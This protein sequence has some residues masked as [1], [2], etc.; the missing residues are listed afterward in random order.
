[1]IEHGAEETLGIEGFPPERSMYET[2]L[3]GSRLHR[4]KSREW[5]FFP[6]DAKS[7]PAL[8][9][10]WRAI[11][12]F[13]ANSEARRLS[14]DQLF[15][16]LRN[17]PFGLKDGI[18]PILAAVML[19][20]FDSEVALYEDG[21]FV[22]RLSDSVFERMFKTPERFELQR[23]RIAGPRF[24]VFRKYAQVLSRT[25]GNEAPD[26]ITLVRP[27]VR[28]V[29]ELPEFVVKTRQLSPTAQALLRAIRE[30][31]QPDKLLFADIP[32]A[33]GFA[34]FEAEG[35]LAEAELDRFFGILRASLAELQRAYPQLLD[36]LKKL[37]ID[38]LD[39][40]GSLAEA[41][42]AID[43]EARLVLNL[44]VDAKL[45]SFLMRAVDSDSDDATWVESIATLL[46]N[47][48]PTAWDDR[49]LAR[50]E[51]ELAAIARSFRHFKVLAFEM[52]RSGFSLLDGDPG[53][54]RVSVTTP[55]SGEF[56]RVVQVPA[57]FLPRA[58]HAKE[59]LLK[60]LEREQLLEK[61]DIS[62]ALLGQL[63]RELLQE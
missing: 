41:R 61:K 38:A 18:L 4:K 27:L 31:R 48:P 20:H 28:L 17:P 21:S 50:F 52:E 2:L 51:V 47:R 16:L 62:V 56:E 59:E 3:R 42:R 15:S 26:L 36:T 34:P 57:E 44:S 30:A 32:S 54:L 33:C 10:V 14:V 46:A 8:A 35:K 5:G 29:R 49:D 11:E 53:M 7:E 6:P 39:Q 9:E 60:V 23:L 1:M 45:K 63:V 12:Q 40:T 58:A 13:L 22:P 25:L 24:E 37:V 55:S 19:L 43:H